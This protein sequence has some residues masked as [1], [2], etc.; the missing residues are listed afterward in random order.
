MSGDAQANAAAVVGKLC[1]GGELYGALT[2]LALAKARRQQHTE[3][4]SN[5]WI[6]Y[7]L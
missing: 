4:V 1:A 2:L 5:L 6:C 7:P 3:D